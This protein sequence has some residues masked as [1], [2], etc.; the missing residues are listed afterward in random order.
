MPRPATYTLVLNQ[1]RPSNGEH[2]AGRPL[3][4][5]GI[6]ADKVYDAT[7]AATLNPAN[8]VLL[9]LFGADSV[10]L[11][12]SGATGTFASKDV[13]SNITV[14]LSGLALD[15]PQAGDYAL[16][17]PVTTT[18]NITPAPVTVTG[19]TAN[20]VYDA[21]THATPN[22]SQAA[23]GGVFG[24]DT[25][26]LITSALTG[27]F[28]SKDVGNSILVVLSGL[29]LGGPQ[30][31]DYVLKQP[32]TTKA[33]ITPAPLTVTEITANDKVYDGT[34]LATL[35]TSSAALAG[36][37]GGDAVTLNTSA[38]TGTF[39]SKD[40]ANNVTV[41]VSGLTLGG[42]KARDYLLTQPTT[43]ANITPPA[44]SAAYFAISAPGSAVAG[45]PVSFTITARDRFNNPAG[46]G[47]TGIIHFS[48]T[49]PLASL[50]AD[51]VLVNGAG[52]FSVTFNSA[53][54]QTISASDTV[55]TGITGSSNLIAVSVPATQF[56]VSAPATATAGAA[57]P[58]TV[59]AQD[60]SGHTAIG[61]GHY[62]HCAT[63]TST[64]GQALLPADTTLANGAGTFLVTLK[65]A[66]GSPWT[67]TATDTLHPGITGTSGNIM[68][69]PGA[70]GYFTLAVP[71]GT[72]TTGSPVNVTVTAHDQ[73]GNIATAYGGHIHFTSSDASAVLPPDSTLSSGTGSF[74]LTLNTA[75]S[76]TITASDT[77]AC[78]N[79]GIMGTSGA[80]TTRGLTVTSFTPTPTG[81]TAT[82]SKPFLPGD[83]T[84]YGIGQS[85]VQDVT[86]VGAHVGRDRR[87]A[88]PGPIEHKHH[89]QRNLQL[90]IVAEQ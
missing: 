43:T 66:T 38:A 11:V 39:A 32:T 44:A 19:I 50:P 23:L 55:S 64:D 52:I 67:F 63:L 60:S 71:A 53:G 56:A 88:A 83:I 87:L 17:Q 81:F 22:A 78:S 47:Y 33:N 72:I 6:A 77:A 59:T 75:G 24:G 54:A 48:S 89:V 4:V 57:F 46:A 45:A 13:A 49:D 20:K 21:T 84:L 3:T 80:I 30:A 69:N 25:M 27:R 34:T 18:A 28:A 42:I 36:V 29:A 40:V 12:A 10:T 76:Q 1:L 62:R 7:I 90:A 61:P 15:G 70:A 9:G 65:T 86:L 79:P 82:F 41:T 2:H 73:F 5:A 68:V 85:T 35:N 74:S 8:A 14:T 51:T 26:T 58:V 31:G 37:L 16:A